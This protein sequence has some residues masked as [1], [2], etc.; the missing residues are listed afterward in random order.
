MDSENPSKMED[1]TD[2]ITLP[3]KNDEQKNTNNDQVANIENS[4]EGD[5][6]LDSIFD[7]IKQEISTE[8]GHIFLS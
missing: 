6:K 1:K 7:S 3:L 8:I 2:S 4:V 5:S